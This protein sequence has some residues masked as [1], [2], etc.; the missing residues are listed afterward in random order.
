MKKII[1]VLFAF[2]LMLT[3]LTVFADFEEDASYKIEK[4]D[5]GTYITV[6]GLETYKLYS[7]LS[8]EKIKVKSD[9][10]Q[11]EIIAD[12]FLDEID[13][14]VAG[15]KAF[16]IKAE[17]AGYYAVVYN[18]KDDIELGCSVRESLN[19]DIEGIF[20]DDIQFYD[21]IRVGGNIFKMAEGESEYVTVTEYGSG[22]YE[23]GFTYLGEKITGVKSGGA[24]IYPYGPEA[25]DAADMNEGAKGVDLYP[26]ILLTFS[27]GKT[28][29]TSNFSHT[30]CDAEYDKPLKAQTEILGEKYDFDVTLIKAES[31]VKNISLPPDFAPSFTLS[32]DGCIYNQKF[33]EYFAVEFADGTKKNIGSGDWVTLSNGKNYQVRA[34]YECN[35]GDGENQSEYPFVYTFDG[36]VYGETPVKPDCEKLSKTL[37]DIIEKSRNDLFFGIRIFKDGGEDLTKADAV[38]YMLSFPKTVTDGCRYYFNFSHIFD[39][40]ALLLIAFSPLILIVLLVLA[41]IFIKRAKKHK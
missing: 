28:L 4:K 5:D 7:D 17:K 15:R 19:K 41:V 2:L 18:S 34:E 36:L 21:G 12:D 37:S 22:E 40:I 16:G 10:V 8:E 35:Y 27:L 29:K 33:P 38:R 11:G 1:S 26:N 30:D 13:T 32:F 39:G 31:L 25:Y 9:F 6:W 23:I 14:S 24:L 20:K 3:P